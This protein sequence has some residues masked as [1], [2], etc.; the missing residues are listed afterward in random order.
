VLV[1]NLSD[2]ASAGK[3]LARLAAKYGYERIGR[4]RLTNDAL[5]AISAARTGIT[6]L[7][8]NSR[9]FARIAEFRAFSWRT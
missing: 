9:D 2:W 1:P 6:V 8:A 7:T 4:A 5:I 3:V